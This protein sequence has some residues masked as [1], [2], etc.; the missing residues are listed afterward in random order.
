LIEPGSKSERY[1]SSG[2]SVSKTQLYDVNGNPV[3]K[4]TPGEKFDEFGNHIDI[5]HPQCFD[6]K[7]NPIDPDDRLE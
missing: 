2:R 7:G 4:L 6:D 1:D 3:D 5:S